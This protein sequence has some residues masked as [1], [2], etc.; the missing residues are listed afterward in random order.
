MNCCPAPAR[1]TS[2][3][4]VS[5]IPGYELLR[6]SDA[7]PFGFAR[8]SAVPG[9]ELFLANPCEAFAEL[10]LLT[11]WGCPHLALESILKF[12]VWSHFPPISAKH[13]IL[14]EGHLLSARTKTPK[15]QGAE[16]RATQA[17]SGTPRSEGRRRRRH[18]SPNH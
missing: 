16:D 2:G 12:R 7:Q 11:N 9:D 5:A 4:H 15:V 17:Y 10:C 8:L 6:A 3:L 1:N 18:S 14:P 13:A